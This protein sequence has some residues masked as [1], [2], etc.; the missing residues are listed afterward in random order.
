MPTNPNMVAIQTVTVG[1]GGAASIDFTNIPQT[2]T[3]L[4]VKLS[5]RTTRTGTDVDDEVRMQFNGSG[6]TAY[7][8]RMIE[9]DGSSTR[10][11][12]DTSQAYFGRGVAP[13]DNATASTFSNC[14]YYIPNYTSSNNKSVS[15]DSTM[16][17]NAT[18]SVMTLT[19]GLWANTAA[20]TSIKVTAI[21]TF[22]QYSTATL[23]GVTS[24]GYGAK[25]TGG[26][27]SQDADYFYH[28]FLASG[29]FTP[30][31]NITCDYLVV[32]G[33]GGGSGTVGGFSGGGAGGLRSTVSNTGG[34]GTLESALSLTATTN[35]TVT[36]GAGGTGGNFGAGTQGGNSV[37]STITSTG[38]G[39]GGGGS[40]P[41]N[42]GSGGSGGG[43]GA[44]SS[45]A[46][47]GGAASP[48]GQGYVGGNAIAG[49]NGTRAGG[50]GGGAGAIGANATSGT[51]G[52]GGNGTWTALS[53]AVQAGQLSSGNY[54]LAGGGGG[55]TLIGTTRGTGGLGGGGAAV[56][57]SPGTAGTTNTGG[58]GAGGDYTTGLD[59]VGG[60]G[61]SGIVIVRYAK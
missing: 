48:S 23:Y 18:R 40:S 4:V 44:D 46:G 27:I 25:A 33:G 19:A 34:G 7:S 54:Y 57:N 31:S 12:S 24:A 35:Y 41:F 61:G 39:F 22:D 10:S 50:S 11:V 20:I 60:N 42:G 49:A 15:F 52:N 16:E 30:T 5:V 45:T 21:G 36:I 28:T 26:I 47:T 58:G 32:A 53:N 6:G 3:D 8:T 13:S 37:F 29:T 51:G 55:A 2:Y 17:N 43:G 1:A 14:E 56:T 38:G 9:G 59:K